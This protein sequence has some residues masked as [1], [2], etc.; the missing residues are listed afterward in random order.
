[1]AFVFEM[2]GNSAWRKRVA[3]GGLAKGAGG[4]I[5]RHRP[6]WG[7]KGEDLKL[8]RKGNIAGGN[9]KKMKKCKKEEVLPENSTAPNNE[10]VLATTIWGLFFFLV[11]VSSFTY[12]WYYTRRE[13]NSVLASI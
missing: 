13:R 5:A 1:M 4:A 8:N 3:S 10:S 11:L 2:G 12:Y 7:R 6:R 9:P